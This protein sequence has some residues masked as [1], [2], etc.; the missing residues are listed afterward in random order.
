LGHVDTVKLL[1]QKGANVKC[2]KITPQNPTGE[3]P[4][5]WAVIKY[6]QTN[7]SRYMEIG[8]LLINAGAILPEKYR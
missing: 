4:L 6:Q 5:E 7:D 2:K 1:I 3:Y 8:Q